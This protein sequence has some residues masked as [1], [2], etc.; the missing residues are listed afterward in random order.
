M[1]NNHVLGMMIFVGVCMAPSHIVSEDIHEAAK[2]G[3][4]VKM[5]IILRESPELLDLPDRSG[6]TPLHWAVIY[7]RKDMLEYLIDRGADV[8]GSD[9]ALHSWT[10]LQAALFAYNNEVSDLLVSHGALKELDRDKGLIYLYMSASSGNA[11]LIAQIVNKGIEVA[12]RNKYGETPLHKAAAKGHITAAEKLLENGA[13]INAKNFKGEAPIHV[14]ELSGQEP[15]V[16]FLRG[17]GAETQ[18]RSF[19]ILEGPYLGMPEPGKKPEI[20]A[21]GIIS[22]DEREHG[23]PIFS[24]DGKEVF[25][26]IQYR[27]RYGQR[28]Q[29]LLHSRMENNRWPDLAKP[30]FS[31]KYR[32]GGGSFSQNGRRFYFHSIRPV[33]RDAER[34]AWPQIWYVEKNGNGWGD[35]VFLGKPVNAE[36]FCGNP[37]MTKSGTLYFSAERRTKNTD[38]YLS[39]Q[40]DGRFQKPEKLPLPISGPHYDSLSFVAPDESF[41]MIYRIDSTGP[42]NMRDLVIFFMRKDGSWSEPISLKDR[43]QLKGSD[44]LMGS[45]SPDGKYLFLLDDMDIYWT[46]AEVLVDLQKTL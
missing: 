29:Y 25:L 11:S 27:E 32:N 37:C 40:V 12:H 22:T 34:N 42:I 10:P 3:D 46:S 8:K 26:C 30:S 15:M 44:I 35:P 9:K 21:P 33:E 28:G 43:L 23:L 1:R 17:K 39:H 18:P 6:Y 20:F 7:G 2:E 14:A 38:V 36:G 4:I 16:S 13:D 19:P 24:P 5:Q 45:V 41:I 31:S